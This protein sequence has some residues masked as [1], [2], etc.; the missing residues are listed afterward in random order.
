MVV[1]GVFLL[2]IVVLVLVNYW[3]SVKRPADKPFLQVNDF[4]YTWS[5]YVRFLKFTKLSSELD[6]SPFDPSTQPFALAQV[7]TENELLRQA[8]A[9]EGLAVTDEDV[10]Q[11]LIARL[12]PNVADTD[13][14][15][16]IDRELE[17]RLS[18]YLARVHLTSR[19][20]ER[21][22]RAALL[23]EQL[24]QKL[25]V[26]VAQF[27][28]HMYLH[29]IRLDD[30]QDVT[31]VQERLARGEDFAS[32]ARSLSD[33]RDTRA[34]GGEVGWTPRLVYNNFDTELFGLREGQVSRPL[35]TDDGYYLVRLLERVDD[36][37][38]LQAILVEDFDAAREVD[39]RLDTGSSFGDLA[40]QVSIDPELRASRGDLGLVGVED[41]GGIFA[42]LIRG[43]ELGEVIGPTGG[44]DL[45][46]RRGVFFLMVADRAAARE[47]SDDNLSTLKTRALEEWLS[48]EQD[49]NNINACPGSLNNCFGSVKVTR[50]L[51]EIKD[52]S[53][54]KFLQGATATA[55]AEREQER[56]PF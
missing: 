12:I 4:V 32:V 6:G 15:A 51:A 50:A 36:K 47:V 5:D 13:D 18:N 7:M 56:R 40:A 42:Q 19:E 17:V 37:A 14:P 28:P 55:V 45:R 34:D 8:A 52:I 54:T 27:Q 24:R 33:D 49:L 29:L 9:R 31:E 21:I 46:G 10:R 2:A 3:V 48:T 11:E 35:K 39:R 38:R 53:L 1:G 26:R 23:R 41:R 25:G 43:V 22:I 20:H 16:Q 44:Q 30:Q